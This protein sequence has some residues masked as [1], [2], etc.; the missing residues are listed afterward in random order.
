MSK[1]IFQLSN[2]ANNDLKDMLHQVIRDARLET[3]DIGKNMDGFGCH[4]EHTG[5]RYTELDIIERFK[6]S[7]LEN[8]KIYFNHLQ[9]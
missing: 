1:H 5:Y 7:L 3:Y 6:S 4:A 2:Y 9:E 8:F